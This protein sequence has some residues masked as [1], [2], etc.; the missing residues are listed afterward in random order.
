MGGKGFPVGKDKLVLWER[1]TVTRAMT[2]SIPSWVASRREKGRLL[3]R[4]LVHLMYWGRTGW[5]LLQLRDI[6]VPICYGRAL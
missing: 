4:C 1:R 2:A 5:C 3:V 6:M